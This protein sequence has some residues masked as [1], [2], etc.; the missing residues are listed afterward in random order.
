MVL[1]EFLASVFECPF[2]WSSSLEPHTMVLRLIDEIPNPAYIPDHMSP[3]NPPF[4]FRERVDELM[5]VLKL[6]R[7]RWNMTVKE[8][9]AWTE[10]YSPALA[11]RGRKLP[12]YDEVKFNGSL[13]FGNSHVSAGLPVPLPQNYINIGGYHIDNNAPHGVIYFSLGT[14][15]K[16]STLP[17]ELKRGFLRTFNELEQTFINIKR[18]VAKGF[19]KQVMIGYDADVKLKEAIDDI[20]QDPK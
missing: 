19:G 13:M 17:E 14:M 8:N 15:M 4:S 3:L 10:A 5:N 1:V 6:Y 16:G 12:P 18:A 20:L 7:I 11:I 2:I 9:K